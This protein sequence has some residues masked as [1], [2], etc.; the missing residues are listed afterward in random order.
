MYWLNIIFV[1]STFTVVVEN[2]L[3][4]CSSIIKITAHCRGVGFFLGGG[5]YV[6]VYAEH[7]IFVRSI[8]STGKLL[9]RYF[10]KPIFISHAL[11]ACRNKL[12]A[13]RVLYK[14]FINENECYKRL[15][16]KGLHVSLTKC[17]QYFGT[18]S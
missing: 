7:V 4:Y 12:Y 1:L 8:G 14:C 3:L 18:W 10:R 6:A 11:Y 17:L 5:A 15:T 16:N 13:C 9:L 2:V